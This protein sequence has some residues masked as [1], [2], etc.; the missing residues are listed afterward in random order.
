MGGA[1]K[2]IGAWGETQACLF[3]QRQ[4][5]T[6]IERNFFSPQGEIDIIATKNGDFYFIEV[7]TR[8]SEEM[9]N[10]LAITKHKQHKFKKTVKQYCY[11]RGVGEAGLILAGLIIL[12]DRT[13]KIA[14]FRLAIFY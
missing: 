1:L 9:A 4:G 8:Q 6:V 14:S 3:L 10:D 7:K 11:E 5:F 2:I 13:T 12:V